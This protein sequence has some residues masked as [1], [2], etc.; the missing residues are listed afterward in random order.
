MNQDSTEAAPRRALKRNAVLY[1]EWRPLTF[2]DVVGQGHVVK[3][4]QNSVRKNRLAH[5]Y[6]FCG[7]RGTGKTTLA[8]ILSRAVNCQNPVDGEPCNECEI[9]R[10]IL[11]GSALDVM[12]IDAAS[13]NS[14]DN[15][16]GLREGIIYAPATARY[17]VYI[18]DEVHMLSGGAFNALLKTLEEPPPYVVFI[19]ATTEPQ[20][21]PATVVSRCQRFD[22]RRIPDDEIIGRLEIIAESLG[23]TVARD[24]L[25]LIA[26]LSEGA[27]RDAISIFDQCVSGVESVLSIGDVLRITGVP[28]DENLARCARILADG[29]AKAV[30]SNVAA[31]VN[32][33]M[34]LTQ[35]A[36]GL[37]GFFRNMLMVKLGLGRDE[38]PEISNDSY[39]TILELNARLEVDFLLAAANEF[40]TLTN[41]LKNSTNQTVM[42]EVA[43][44]KMC[45]GRFHEKGAVDAL[46]AR[47]DTLEKRIENAARAERQASADIWPGDDPAADRRASAAAWDEKTASGAARDDRPTA[48]DDR[49][50]AR[51]NAQ[52]PATDDAHAA[53]ETAHGDEDAAAGIPGQTGTSAYRQ[54]DR[55]LWNKILA[56]FKTKGHLMLF[57]LLNGAAAATLDGNFYI[58]LP[59]ARASHKSMLAQPD[60]ILKLQEVIQT[61]AGI[62]YGIR[63]VNES[64][65]ARLQV[66]SREA[67]QAQTNDR[68]S[69]P[70]RAEDREATQ[71]EDREAAQAHNKNRNNDA[72][73]SSSSVEP[74]RKK[75]SFSDM[76][77]QLNE[78]FNIPTNIYP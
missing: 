50:T 20:K 30:P 12:E 61:G 49:P 73:E 6:L 48:R 58:V 19:L 5:A 25:R 78:K 15:V 62:S 55:A 14:V 44:A 9:C 67:A 56:S 42:F 54:V 7:V 1:R 18:I 43:L 40:A 66:N 3:T 34:S 51:D 31:A 8:Q 36:D 63:I 65:A 16:R 71:A 70:A 47:I 35:Y 21:L 23:V 53:R 37:A 13:N 17:K 64:E 11:S 4:L 10:G 32:A 28:D 45:L 26:K 59:D 52:M 33:G 72:V 60:N 69:A 29:D 74:E 22:F 76:A 57:S 77:R 24:A 75:L 27:L 46:N 41:G 39:E 38:F 68:G 2:R